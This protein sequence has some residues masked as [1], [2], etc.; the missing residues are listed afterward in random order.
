MTR[1]ACVSSAPCPAAAAVNLGSPAQVPHVHLLFVTS[2]RVS[3]ARSDTVAAK[4]GTLFVSS[5]ARLH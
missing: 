5:I 2:G 3:F 4:R 1:S